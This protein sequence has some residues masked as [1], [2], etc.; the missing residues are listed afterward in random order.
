VG[1]EG[2]VPFAAQVAKSAAVPLLV[3]RVG[4]ALIFKRA[5]PPEARKNAE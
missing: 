1:L 3:G 2:D 5:R 4:E